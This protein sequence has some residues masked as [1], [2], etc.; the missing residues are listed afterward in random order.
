MENDH[1]ADG[2]PQGNYLKG[3]PRYT[4]LQVYAWGIHRIVNLK[5]ADDSR[6]SIE[7]Y[8]KWMRDHPDSIKDPEMIP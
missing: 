3:V 6:R 7:W 8:I 1:D 4:V 5:D 2:I